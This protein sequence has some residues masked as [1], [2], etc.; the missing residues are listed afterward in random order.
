MIVVSEFA[1]AD[2]FFGETLTELG[3]LDILTYRNQYRQ[4]NVGLYGINSNFNVKNYY[5]R[6]NELKN[7][8]V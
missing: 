2:S 4:V 3:E 6:S 8:L 5:E 7:V 1:I